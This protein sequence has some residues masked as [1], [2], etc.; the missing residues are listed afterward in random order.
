MCLC[1][2]SDSQQITKKSQTKAASQT[3]TQT[4]RS[5]I[6]VN[7]SRTIRNTQVRSGLRS[8]VPKNA[9]QVQVSGQG[10]PETWDLT[11]DLLGEDPCG[12]D[13]ICSLKCGD[14]IFSTLKTNNTLLG[15]FSPCYFP[16]F[17]SLPFPILVRHTPVVLRLPSSKPSVLTSRTLRPGCLCHRLNYRKVQCCSFPPATSLRAFLLREGDHKYFKFLIFFHSREPFLS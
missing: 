11:C 16:F 13:F 1:G 4:Y 17:K 15:F 14:S 12:L 10:V 3:V 9:G 2:V 5:Q 6:T 7:R 8:G